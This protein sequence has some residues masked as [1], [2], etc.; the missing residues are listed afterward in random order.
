MKKSS[1]LIAS[2]LV[3][4]LGGT[5]SAS[6]AQN[7]DTVL[8]PKQFGASV[9][10]I[11]L[12]TAALQGAIDA[13]HAAGGGTVRLEP[14]TYLSGTLVLRSGVTLHLEKGATLLG[15]PRVA[16]Y[17]R[18]KWPAL[19]LAQD[20]ERIAVTGDGVI[21]GQGKLVA[22]DT[23]RIFESGLLTDFFP[24][25][26]PGQT[27][28]LGGDTNKGRLIDPHALLRSGSLAAIVAPRSRADAATWRVDEAVR[29][30]LIEF[31][32]CHDVR[33]RGVTLRNAANWVQSYRL[34]DEVE[35]TD[36]R[37]ESTSYWNNDGLDIVNCRRVRIADCD[38]NA[39]DD[40]IC[41]KT[42]PNDEGRGCE[43]VVIERCRLR[44]SASAVKLG[45]ASHHDFRRIHI[46]NIEIH[47]TYRSAIALEVVDGGVIEDLEIRN[48]KARNTGNAFFLR[49]GQRNPDR[50]PG[51]LRQVLLSDFEVEVPTGKPDAGYEHE[52]PPPKFSS[53]LM[54][55]SIAGLP[56]RPIENIVLRN[57]RIVY[58]GGGRR[59]VAEI[60][61]DRLSS[62]PQRRESYPEFSMFGELPAWA[63]YL[64]HIHG[65]RL[66][67]VRLLLALPDYRP[68]L[69]ADDVM[70]L[71]IK[72][73]ELDPHGARPPVILSS[74]RRDSLSD[75]QWTAGTGDKAGGPLVIDRR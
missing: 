65:I 71:A 38:I 49:L 7:T 47:D 53:N 40:G 70:G 28:N 75:I 59:E 29:P 10:G 73:A 35:I 37:V 25:V 69:V 32:R 1:C 2:L 21:D 30:Q 54:P 36:V 18:G 20:Q 27:V 57:I 5:P 6:R 3:V 17:R 55:A 34:C 22:A 9:D 12:D 48:I 41:L 60:P 58:G 26:A 67:N 43:D 74:V 15:S 44:T 14:G 42:E 23:I 19:L 16:D 56:D 4:A 62:V 50:P 33:V 13:A 68:A 66:E 46:R 64:R 72:G 39:A 52:G 24:G 31:S 45:T 61:P 51:S 8:S 11:T 63:L